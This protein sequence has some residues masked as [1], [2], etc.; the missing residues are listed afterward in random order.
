MLTDQTPVDSTEAELNRLENRQQLQV[1]PGSQ[2]IAGWREPYNIHTAY[3]YVNYGT[4]CT[5]EGGIPH[6]VPSQDFSLVN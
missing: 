5:L 1:M 6:C 2:H 3:M 4:H